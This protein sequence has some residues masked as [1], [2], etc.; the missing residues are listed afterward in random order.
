MTKVVYIQNFDS[1][2]KEIHEFIKL[3][4][5]RGVL[6]LIGESPSGK[7]TLVKKYLAINNLTDAT[8]LNV[9][10]FIMTKLNKRQDYKALELDDRRGFLNRNKKIIEKMLSNKFYDHFKNYNLLILD[11]IELALKY[12]INLAAI[13]YEPASGGNT[14]IICVPGSIT[15]DKIFFLNDPGVIS[16]HHCDKIIQIQRSS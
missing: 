10:D 5:V 16:Y 14:C 7:T 3:R 4:K 9:N 1:G 11:S 6:A 2:L 13:A 8:Y 15:G 12:Q